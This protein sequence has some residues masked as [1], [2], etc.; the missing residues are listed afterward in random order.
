MSIIIKNLNKSYKD[1]KILENLNLEIKSGEVFGLLGPNGA[2]KTTLISIL[3]GLINKDSGEV[4]IEELELDKNNKEIKTISSFVPQNYAFYPNLTVFENLE[5]FGSL[6]G[7]KN[8]KLKNKIFMVIKT[9]SL[10]KYIHK[11]ALN[12]SGGIKRRLNIAIGLLNSPKFL[13][14]DEP[15]VGID[16][17][18]RR[19]ILDVIKNINKSLKTTIIYTS[20]YMEEIEYICDSFAILDEKKIVYQDSIKNLLET[21]SQKNLEEMFLEITK[22]SL[23]D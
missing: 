10:E 23:R 3:N 20:H 5:F 13:Y 18:S 15:T 4:F 8:E 7:L 6:Y 19:Y 16:P 9:C 1:M 2:G 21:N 11:R 12:F 22:K 14:L 17:H